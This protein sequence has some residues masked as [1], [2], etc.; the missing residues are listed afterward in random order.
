MNKALHMRCSWLI[1][2][3]LLTALAC[4]LGTPTPEPTV[5]PP[6]AP[7]VEIPLPT[8]TPQF[9]GVVPID[10]PAE[11]KD[12]A[13]DVDASVD[14]ARQAVTAGD[15]FVHG[16]YER[17]LNA[18]TMDMYFPYIDIIDVQG[19][20]DDTWGYATITLKDND[21]SGGL[22]AQ[23][24]VELDLDRDGRGDWL[25]R[26]SNPGSTEWSTLGV[27][28]WQNTDGDIGGVAV[29]T[30]DSKPLGGNGY[31]SL[32]FDEGK[33]ALTDGAWARIK[34]DDSRTLEIAFKLSMLGSPAHYAMSAWAGTTL[35]PAMFD[36][37]DHMTH[38]D[39]G[40]PNPGYEVYP[41]KAMA[42]IDNTCRLA[43]GFSPTGK[44]PGLCQTVERRER[45]EA[46][47][48]SLSCHCDPCCP[49]LCIWICD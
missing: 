33:G 1:V 27:R 49:A 8:S 46:P 20:Q 7:P 17:P 21:S 37:H 31:E 15:V 16:L 32:V 19:F 18:D 44:E 25:I 10:L 13:G 35:D 4:G 3:L 29:M 11:R 48:G 30:A 22:G 2:P 12:H 6:A 14:A 47:A 45:E 24:G 40:S 5:P 26:A 23:Y 41:L 9:Q 42:E 43:V 36:H 28:A 38:L 39:A 34:A